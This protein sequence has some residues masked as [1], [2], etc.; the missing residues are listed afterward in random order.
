MN[1]STVIKN[2]KNGTVAPLYIDQCKETYFSEQLICHL[3]DDFLDD[4]G[5]FNFCRFDLTEVSMSEVMAEAESYS[6]F[7]TKKVIYLTHLSSLKKEEEARW[8]HYLSHLQEEVI[9]VIYQGEDKFD[10]RK[11]WVKTL[12]NIATVIEDDELNHSYYQEFV[13]THIA[14]CSIEREDALYIVDKT[15]GNLSGIAQECQQLMLY[16]QEGIISREVID[17]IVPSTVEYHLFDISN[18][19]MG[20]HLE[21]ALSLY[22]ELLLQGEDT[23]KMNFLLMMQ[24]RL[25][26]QVKILMMQRMSPKEISKTLGVHPYRVELAWRQ[27]KQQD[28][29]FLGELYSQFVNIDYQLKHSAMDQDMLFELML[30]YLSQ[31]K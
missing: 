1:Y 12:L 2:I 13:Q 14:P 31:V 6:F 28:I 9:F 19:I 15:G 5:E 11:K 22:H 25:Y 26:I 16:Q 18:N 24:F 3:K 21:E 20:R 17:F 8:L 23:I 10:K 30:T 7:A 4:G 29:A 27:V